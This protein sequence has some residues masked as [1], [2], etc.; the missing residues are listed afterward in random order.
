METVV[1]YSVYNVHNI[2]IAHCH[3]RGMNCE[4]NYGNCYN[5]I[6]QGKCGAIFKLWNGDPIVDNHDWPQYVHVYVEISR[7]NLPFLCDK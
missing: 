2:V 1:V 6:S 4:K 5:R 7:I 3:E